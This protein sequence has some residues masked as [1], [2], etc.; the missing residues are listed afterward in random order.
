MNSVSCIRLIRRILIFAIAFGLSACATKL[1]PNYDKVVAD[2]LVLVNT[3]A[4]TL[5][6]N[7]SSGSKANTFSAREE[8]YNALI[9]KI[10]A[11]ALQ[12]GARPMPNNKVSGA[13]NRALDKRASQPLSDDEHTPPSAHAIKKIAEA[14]IMMRGT[15]RKQGVTET[16]VM[17]FKGQIAIYLDQA[18]TY[19]NFLQR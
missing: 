1:A 10:E 6:A 4:M 13:I 7:I 9:G 5:L 19:E 11:L 3:E 17:A 2:G 8:K 14:F 15:D 18:I 12:A 16:E